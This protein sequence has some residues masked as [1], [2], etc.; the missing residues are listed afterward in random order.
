MVLYEASTGFGPERFPDVPPE[1]MRDSTDNDAL[2]FY[3]IALKAGEGLRE[4]RYQSADEMQAD[5]ALL[6]SGQSIR[7]MR[8]IKRRYARLRVALAVGTTLFVCALTAFFF[9]SYRARLA[10]ASKARETVLRE[11]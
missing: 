11:Q 1:W 2:E 10:A 8:T 6:Q 7:H 5:L 4:R 3:E 9:A